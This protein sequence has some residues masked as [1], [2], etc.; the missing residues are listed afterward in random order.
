MALVRFNRRSPSAAFPGFSPSMPSF[1]DMATRMNRFFERP[2]DDV[3]SPSSL[4]ETIGWMPA[5]DIVETPKELMLSAE[6]PGMALKNIDV[7]V[8]AG[9]L[10]IRGEKADER[11]SAG[12]DKVH[13]YERS[14]GSFERAF[15]LPTT[16]DSGKITAEFTNG[17]LKV[18][19][20][21][22]AETK[23]RGRKVEISSA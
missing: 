16:V 10:T 7:S 5:M 2:F 15:V 12:A 21:K 8:D 3:F 14:F 20:P 4:T 11:K 23:P 22:D 17:V 13:L 1:D 6:L 9:I 18:H 19:L